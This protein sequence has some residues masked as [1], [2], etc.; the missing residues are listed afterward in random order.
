M[1]L[2]TI[3]VG[4]PLR[5]ADY[6]GDGPPIVLV[7]GLGGLH[8]NWMRIAP[9][10]TRHGRVLAVD[11]PGFGGTPPLPGGVS[12]DGFEATMLRFLD[13]VAPGPLSLAGNSLGGALSVLLAAHLGDR[14]KHLF[15]FS[16][17]VPHAYFEPFDLRAFFTMGAAMLPFFGAE[18]V[19]ERAVR[20]GPE[21]LVR[22]MMA[23]MTHDRKRVPPEVYAAHIA[24][25]AERVD[26]P[27]VGTAFTEA[28]RS[29]SWTLLHRDLFAEKVRSIKAAGVAFAGDRDRL[30]RA[31]S[32]REMASLNP[33]FRFHSWEDVGHVAQLEVPERVLA[34]LDA[35]FAEHDASAA[36]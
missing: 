22:E 4:V 35:H 11:L 27:W 8:L 17:A 14:V 16:P 18:S 28:L 34:I 2:R 33:R 10:L 3:D 6:G 15:L 30:V 26:R 20:V 36:A 23:F 31:R 25:A 32:V 19:R 5:Y 7:H 13:A 1:Q 21:R 29:L 12:M 24:E 9:A